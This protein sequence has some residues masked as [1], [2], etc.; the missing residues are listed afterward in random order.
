M[1]RLYIELPAGT[2]VSSVSLASLQ[3]R[4]RLAFAPYPFEFAETAWWSAYAIGQ[5]HADF[6]HKNYRAFQPAT[7]ATH[8]RPSA[9]A[10]TPAGEDSDMV[11]DRVLVLA[12][13][14]K[15]VEQE[16]IPEFFTPVAGKWG[17]KALTKVFSDDESYSSGHGHAYEAPF[18]PSRAPPSLYDLTIVTTLEDSEAIHDVFKGSL[19]PVP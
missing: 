13:E 7:P 8:T 3:D 16:Q 1:V 14:R 15:K 17:I 4:A 12:G 18:P 5:R 9:K 6:F 11:V 10:F 19:V 2:A